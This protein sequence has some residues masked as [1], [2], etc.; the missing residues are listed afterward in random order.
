[1]KFVL[2]FVALASVAAVNASPAGTFFGEGDSGL[3]ALES[4]QVNAKKIE[5]AA[6]DM[7]TTETKLEALAGAAADILAATTLVTDAAD[8]DVYATN[9]FAHE[10]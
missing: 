4:I 8:S 3:A 5:L 1:M 9:T 2:A 7:E 10:T 6:T